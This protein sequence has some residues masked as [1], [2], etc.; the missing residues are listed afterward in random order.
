MTKTRHGT[1]GQRV[2]QA[3]LELEDQIERLRAD[4]DL[5]DHAFWLHVDGDVLDQAV[6]MLEQVTTAIEVEREAPGGIC[7]L[8]ADS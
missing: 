1:E 6:R 5:D 8:G 3:I 2:I 4:R 7:Y